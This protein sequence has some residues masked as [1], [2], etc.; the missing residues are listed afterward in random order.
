LVHFILDDL[1]PASSV[2]AD[3]P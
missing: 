2:Q 1:K 3:P